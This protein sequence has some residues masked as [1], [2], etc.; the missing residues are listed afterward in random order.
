MD[1]NVIKFEKHCLCC[2][3]WTGFLNTVYMNSGL[4][5]FKIV[6]VGFCYITKVP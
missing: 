5:I 2:S 3:V 4:K 1:M 6:V